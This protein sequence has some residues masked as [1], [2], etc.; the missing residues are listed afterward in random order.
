MTETFYKC[1][2]CGFANYVGDEI[3]YGVQIV[4]NKCEEAFDANEDTV[5][6]EE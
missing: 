3:G 2:Y 5:L 4:C 1:P 6:E